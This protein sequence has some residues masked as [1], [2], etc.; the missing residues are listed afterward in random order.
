VEPNLGKSTL[1][2][3]ADYKSSGA[4]VQDWV[5]TTSTDSPAAYYTASTLTGAAKC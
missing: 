2:N 1:D 3:Y 5:Y 4:K